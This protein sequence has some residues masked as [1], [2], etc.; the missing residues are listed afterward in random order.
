MMTLINRN[1]SAANEKAPVGCINRQ[2]LVLHYK[3]ETRYRFKTY[4]FTIVDY[5]L[6]FQVGIY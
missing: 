5:H 1:T 6:C 4:P 2:C 3:K